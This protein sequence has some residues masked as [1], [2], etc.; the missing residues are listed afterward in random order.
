MARQ[1]VLAILKSGPGQKTPKKNQNR[2]KPVTGIDKF[3]VDA[4][5]S[6]IYEMKITG[7]PISV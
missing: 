2:E 4:M 3:A 1:S 6:L 7:R 5:R